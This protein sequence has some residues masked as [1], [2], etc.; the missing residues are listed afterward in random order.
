MLIIRAGKIA[1][2][3]ITLG[4]EVS[5]DTVDTLPLV[6]NLSATKAILVYR[7]NG[8]P[9]NAVARVV[10]RAALVMT[11]GASYT[12]AVNV[13]PT[14]ICALTATLAVVVYSGFV[15]ALGIAGDVVTVGTPVAQGGV[16]TAVSR[17]SDTAFIMSSTDG[18]SSIPQARIGTVSGTA[19]TLGTAAAGATETGS[20]N[21]IVALSSTIALTA[22]VHPP[23][24]GPAAP[25]TIRIAAVH[26]IT[27]TTFTLGDDIELDSDV[28]AAG[29]YPIISAL[30]STR[31]VVTYWYVA[32]TPY[33]IKAV[34]VQANASGVISAGSSITVSEGITNRYTPTIMSVS[35]QKA[36]AGYYLADNPETTQYAYTRSL[37]VSGTTLTN[38]ENAEQMNADIGDFGAVPGMGMTVMQDLS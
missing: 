36:M 10:T 30:S 32:A 29:G 2:T 14:G 22:Y 8:A 26:S 16:S 13:V 5:V 1:G 28:D 11:A 38:D 33:I 27:G 7:N 3:T 31:A 20:L 34:A 6:A 9:N 37:S 23:P 12:I 19:I 24:P 35:S 21:G 15:V 4:S 25:N 18:T 17:L